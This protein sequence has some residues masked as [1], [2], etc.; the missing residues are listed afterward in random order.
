MQYGVYGYRKSGGSF[1]PRSNCT[2][3][4]TKSVEAGNVCG[5]LGVVTNKDGEQK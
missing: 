3:R 4:Y 1:I 5:Y 2:I